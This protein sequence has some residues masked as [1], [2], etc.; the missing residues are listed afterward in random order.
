MLLALIL[1]LL[2]LL[3]RLVF[4]LGPNVELVT[5]TTIVAAIYLP[6]RVRFLVP[7]VI[8]AVSDWHL[9]MGTISWF[10]WSGF[11]VMGF[12]PQLMGKLTRDNWLRG[13][14]A[15][16]VGVVWFYVWTNL[17]VWL[18]DSWGM[19][20]RDGWGLYQ[21]YVNGLPFF[22]NNLVSTMVFVPIGIGLIELIR[23][24]GLIYRNNNSF[25]T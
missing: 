23:N 11:L 19:Y 2:A 5:L 8:M 21:C 12:L 1:I 22:R 3:E 18:T 25:R 15:G 16:L 9:G 7:M 4:D 6:R 24:K 10:T 20:S 14:G 17:G 13:V